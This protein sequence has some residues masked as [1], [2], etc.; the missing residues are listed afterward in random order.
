M[1]V[2]LTCA[3]AAPAHADESEDVAERSPAT[4]PGGT[5]FVPHDPARGTGMAAVASW[6]GGV[7][8]TGAE[9]AAASTGLAGTGLAGRVS[10]GAG[11]SSGAETG[12]TVAI[13]VVLSGSASAMWL[14]ISR[15]NSSRSGWGAPFKPSRK[16]AR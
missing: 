5:V 9:T 1:L 7:S 3:F 13:L 4:A 14:S 6:T 10:T 16:L 8:L 11:A 2:A 12:T 15:T